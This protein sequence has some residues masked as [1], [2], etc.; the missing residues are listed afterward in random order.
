MQ[1]IIIP[2]AVSGTWCLSD[3]EC[4]AEINMITI[5]DND[6]VLWILVCWSEVEVVAKKVK[7]LKLML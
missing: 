5:T 2:K 3:A 4:E 7:N 6:A 1:I